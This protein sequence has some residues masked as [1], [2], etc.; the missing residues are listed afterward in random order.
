[1]RDE[2]TACVPSPGTWWMVNLKSVPLLCDE[3]GTR[4]L[5]EQRCFPTWAIYE[6]QTRTPLHSASGS[7][8]KRWSPNEECEKNDN[9]GFKKQAPCQ[10]NRKAPGVGAGVGRGGSEEAEMTRGPEPQTTGTQGLSGHHRHSTARGPEEWKG[11][12]T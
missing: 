6:K 8:Q 9:P 1:M 5:Q 2:G 11:H 7:C 12:I 3:E 4:F 10:R